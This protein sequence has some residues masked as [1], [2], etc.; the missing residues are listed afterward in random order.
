MNVACE[1]YFIVCFFF[2]DY[3]LHFYKQRFA[4]DLFCNLSDMRYKCFV[5]NFFRNSLQSGKIGSKKLTSRE[6]SNVNKHDLY[7][8]AIERN[9]RTIDFL[10]AQC[11]KI[12]PRKYS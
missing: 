1:H 6:K 12:T 10:Y 9:I 11:T 3:F 5:V 4:H 8:C 7:D 2:P